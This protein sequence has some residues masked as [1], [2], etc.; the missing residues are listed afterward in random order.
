M[1]LITTVDIERPAADVFAYIA[2]FEHN[3]V[4]QGGMTSCR[5]TS[6]GP[7]GVGSTY[8]QVASFLGRPI[9]TT[10]E[11]TAFTPG[12][13]ISIESL[14][15]TFPIQVTRSVQPLGDGACRVTANVAGQPPLLMRLLPGMDWMVKR[16]VRS[17]YAKLKDLLESSP[18]IP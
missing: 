15:S 17:D 1:Q 16:S 2:E 18:T 7:I 11:V 13:T 8:E 12:E 10:F 5:W 14:V 9:R 4:W 3:P 6:E